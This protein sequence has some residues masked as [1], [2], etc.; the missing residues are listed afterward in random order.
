M[1]S[2]FYRKYKV[3]FFAGTGVLLAIICLAL[4]ASSRLS[5][6]LQLAL[7][8]FFLAAMAM[9]GLAYIDKKEIEA[10]EREIRQGMPGAGEGAA[11]GPPP[12]GQRLAL[13]LLQ[14]DDYD[15]V[16]QEIPEEKR[17]LLVAAVDK[18]LRDWATAGN[19]Y[20]RK[21]GRDR[22]LALIPAEALENLEESGFSVFEQL[23]QVKVGDHLPVTV[24]IGIGKGGGGVDPA[25]LGQLAHQ[26]VELAL[27]RGGDQIVV[28]SP[29]H[30]WFY[31]GRSEAIVR[32]SQVRARIAATELDRL[33]R[34][35]G[36]VVIMGHSRIDFDAFGAAVGLAEA[37]GHYGKEV[38]IV[39]DHP[40]GAIERLYE[41]I[42]QKHPDLLVEG[43]EIEGSISSQTLLILV[44]VHRS[45][46]VPRASLISR[47]GYIGVIDHH[48]RG[49]D[50]PE[51]ANLSH[52]DPAA[53]STCEMVAELLRYLP[54]E[55]H[56]TSLTATALLAGIVV[57]TKKFT[58]ATT[59]R[60]FR[61]AALLRDAGARQGVI[62]SLFTD[63]LEVMRYRAELLKKATIFLGKYAISGSEDRFPEAHVAAS[64][65]ADTLLEVEGVAAS[66]VFYP[67]DGG[68]GISA[69][70]NG[71]VNVHL[72]M[73]KMGG[74][75]H[76]TVAGAKLQGT[77]LAAARE[78]LLEI[79][80]GEKEE[81]G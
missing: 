15:E 63:S 8:G 51:R 40:G 16:F 80:E 12:F 33:F 27:A 38:R 18:F 78:R 81:E 53:S 48:R 44:D 72:I 20:L 21:D 32:R 43:K 77:G 5:D 41:L 56:L 64:R 58:F 6:T 39:I 55:I 68:I 71:S 10:R 79:L 13:A 29:E 3:R 37:A 46:M 22:Y 31:G 19:I 67:I 45:N 9:S 66:F 11:A 70:S 30:T 14:V 69:R 75:G 74:G 35:C 62:R 50:F 17:P 57:D 59:A 28:K 1:N 54:E 73:E 76:F 52:I 42:R 25:R 7:F 26:A 49:E 24:S 2:S 23:K 36:S 61:A 65:A 4:A 47:A 60:T 34:L